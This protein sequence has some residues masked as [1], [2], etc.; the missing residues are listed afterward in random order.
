MLTLPIKKK[1]FDMIMAG[2]KKEEYRERKQYYTSRFRALGLLDE[3]YRTTGARAMIALRNGYK[4]TDPTIYAAV[5]M[6]IGKGKPEWGAK[7]G[8]N[9]YILEIKSFDHNDYYL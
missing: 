8:E 7:P 4:K 9:Y 3:K 2:E 6:R 1:W 5:T